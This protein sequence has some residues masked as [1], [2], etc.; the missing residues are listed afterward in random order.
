MG[1]RVGHGLCVRTLRLCGAAVYRR[2]AWLVGLLACVGALAVG[3]SPASAILIHLRTGKELGYQPISGQGAK[4]TPG[5]RREEVAV[6]IQCIPGEIE[7]CV[8]DEHGRRPF[9]Q[10]FYMFT[11]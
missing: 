6:P 4:S 1:A 3:A 9:C 7:V 5:L 10:G 11:V 8:E 2:M